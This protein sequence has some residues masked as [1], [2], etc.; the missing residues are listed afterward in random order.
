MRRLISVVSG[1]RIDDHHISTSSNTEG[2]E[3]HGRQD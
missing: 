3:S 2:S 1:E